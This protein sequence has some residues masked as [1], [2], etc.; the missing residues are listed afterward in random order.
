MFLNN[1]V[2]AP[3]LAQWQH[4]PGYVDETISKRWLVET[5]CRDTLHTRLDKLDV[6]QLSSMEST[7]SYENMYGNIRV[8]WIDQDEPTSSILLA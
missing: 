2:N 4:E 6:S 3:V 7:I 8:S 1:L 5:I